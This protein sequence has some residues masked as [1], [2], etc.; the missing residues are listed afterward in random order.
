MHLFVS[1]DLTFRYLKTFLGKNET[2]KNPEKY[3]KPQ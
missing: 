3:Y 1:K 2:I